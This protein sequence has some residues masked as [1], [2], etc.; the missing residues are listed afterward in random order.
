MWQGDVAYLAQVGRSS[1][2]ALCRRAATSGPPLPQKLTES[3][4]FLAALSVR[5]V[6]RQHLL[7]MLIG[8]AQVLAAQVEDL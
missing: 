4:Y 7:T 6:A 3:W 5:T 8:C 1:E 2:A